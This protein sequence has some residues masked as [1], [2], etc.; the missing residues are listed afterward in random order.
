M[1]LSYLFTDGMVLQAKKPVRLFG[2]G[3]GELKVKFLGK[4]YRFIIEKNAWFVELDSFD[5][6]GPYTMTLS[7]NG[8]E[9]TIQNVCIGEVLLCIGQSNMGFTL[10]EEKSDTDETL[11][12]KIRLFVVDSIEKKPLGHTDGWLACDSEKS[13]YFSA[14]AYHIAEKVH[15]EKNCHV[16]CLCCY[17]GASNIQSWIKK[18]YLTKDTFVPLNERDMGVVAEPYSAWT[19]DGII[20]KKSFKYAL[21]YL[22]STAIWYQGESNTSKSEGLV[23]EKLL[24][25]FVKCVRRESKN[26]DLPF[27][28]VQICDYVYRNDEFWRGIQEVQSRADAFLENAKV[29]TSSDVCEHL[30]IHPENKK[31]LAKKIAKLL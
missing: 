9:K 11:G 1:K 24:K 27:I 19:A 8:K 5:Y 13:K 30:S 25:Q 26:E 10:E 17:Q 12:D 15:E 28:I 14:L 22:V 16:G 7:L 31:E 4:D 3:K 21:D 2:T 20:Y 6:G 23:Y 18:Q 29:V